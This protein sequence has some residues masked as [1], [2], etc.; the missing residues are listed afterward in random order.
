MTISAIQ[1]R[2]SETQVACNVLIVDDSAVARGIIAHLLDNVQEVNVVASA[3][4]GVMALKAMAKHQI[5]VVI[6]DIEMPEMDGMETLP[7]LLAIDPD[8][9][10]IM[11]SSV[12]RR[13]A[14]I[15]LKALSLGACDYVPKPT[16]GLGNA[17]EFRRELLEKV[18]AHGRH[19]KKGQR[20]V[21][22][23][24][25][26]P[27]SATVPQSV[28]APETVNVP[29]S[30][31]PTVLWK[32]KSEA[33]EKPEVI[34]IGSSTGGP[35]ALAQV[36]KN[37]D[38]AVTQPIVITQHMP[39]TFTALLA[40]HMTKYSGRPAC[41]GV[42]GARLEKGHIY[43]A[44]GGKHML[45]EAGTSGGTFIR[46]NDGPPENF[47][48]PAVDPMLRSLVKTFGSRL[49]VIILT[50]MGSDGLK[51]C[52]E[53]V[54]AGGTVFAQDQAT[55]IVWGMPGAVAQAGICREIIPLNE[56]NAAIAVFAKGTG[57]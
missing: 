4:N 11:A 49:L 33:I 26:A 10:V 17:E 16:T 51:G 6:L 39:A 7:R 32:P 2:Q 31:A 15:S 28:T 54:N 24:A 42:D 55:S 22:A 20:R 1:R 30:K 56:I 34:A 41:E 27:Q 43:I 25:N 44:P 35:K 40:E 38:P 13:N 53:I 14:D 50:G 46:L 57:K 8:I 45:L 18:L 19:R 3:P 21:V 36:L 23:S 47:C 9:K 52:R 37:L 12:S 29:A 48:K 5:D